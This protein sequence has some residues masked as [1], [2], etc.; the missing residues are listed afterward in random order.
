LAAV[1]RLAAVR[2]DALLRPWADKAR[3]EAAA[4]P[5]RLRAFVVAC[6]RVADV[7]L[8]AVF[9]VAVFFVAAF[10]LAAFFAGVFRAA[11]VPVADF[12]AGDFLAEDFL[13]DDFRAVDDFRPVDDLPAVDVFP[14][15]A[16]LSCAAFFLVAVLA[17]FDGLAFTPARR[18]LDKPIAIACLA[19]RA[20]CLPSRICSISSCTNSPA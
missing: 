5:S 2:L 15:A 6:E 12:L 11:D 8:A 20:P 19:E 10:R 16:L 17:V 3:L 13:A 9:R 7:F 4:P 18:A 14:A 1:L